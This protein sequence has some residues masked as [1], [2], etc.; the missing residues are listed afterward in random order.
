MLIFCTIAYLHM[1]TYNK[2][3]VITI[4][5][6]F[7]FRLPLVIFANIK[8]NIKNIRQSYIKKPHYFSIS[9]IIFSHT[10][11]IH[12]QY[13]IQARVQEFV[14]G[15]GPKSESLFFFFF[16]FFFLL[17]NFSG[18]GAQLRN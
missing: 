9:F 10:L 4:I 7:S 3:N 2:D 8:F 15:G 11:S 14:R 17:F 12:L 16:F 18:G 6:N 5:I 1:S 13:S